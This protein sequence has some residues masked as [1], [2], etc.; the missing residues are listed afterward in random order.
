[1]MDNLQPA[2]LLHARDYRD[3]CLLVELFTPEQGRISAVARGARR[4]R[5]GYS[6]RAILQPFQP[7]WIAVSGRGELKTLR[8]AESRDSPIPLHGRSL[9]SGLYL[10]ELLCRLLHRDDPHP[11]LFSDYEAALRALVN[12]ELLDIVLRFFELRLLDELG[13]SFSLDSEAHSGVPIAADRQYRF[14]AQQGL[15]RC[16]ESSPQVSFSGADLIAF[17]RGDYS[18]SARRAL[19]VLC[20]LALRPH[21]GDKPLLSRQLFVGER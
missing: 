11:D 4:S 1:M 2:C 10:N 17:N 16:E 3:A 6:Q 19:K 13:Y 12:T 8:A 7:L 15:L 5:K 21:L 18:E 14:D 20:R 9:F